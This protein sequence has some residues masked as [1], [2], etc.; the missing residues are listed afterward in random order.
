MEAAM[1]VEAEETPDIIWWENFFQK[2]DTKIRLA[3]IIDIK[4]IIEVPV[5]D[6]STIQAYQ[7]FQSVKE[8]DLHVRSYLKKHKA[9]LSEGNIAVLTSVWRHSVKF[10]G[11]SFAKVDTIMKNTGVSRSTVIRTINRLVETRLLQRLKT[12]K[13]NGKQGANLLI[14]LPQDD[15]LSLVDDTPVDTLPDTPTKSTQPTSINAGSLNSEPETKHKPRVN[16]DHSKTVSMDA[17]YLPSFIPSSFAN[18]AHSFFPLQEVERVWRTIVTAYRKVNLTQPLE[19]Y[20]PQIQETFK[21]A[22]YVFK[23]G[24]VKA[25]FPSYLYGGMIVAFKKCVH[26]EV[27]EDED[28]VYYDWLNEG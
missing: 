22:I 4:K 16:E 26:Q 24:K 2:S 11:V 14:I 13:P 3:S 28:T 6:L 9:K 20:L 7:S 5:M 8:M 15:L 21:Q 17:S 25:S 10:P 1:S 19:A 18:L 23:N 27:L 12:C